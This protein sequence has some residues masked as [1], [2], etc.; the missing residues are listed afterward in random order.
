VHADFLPPLNPSVLTS[1][2]VPLEA[3]RARIA[4]AGEADADTAL[5]IV[6]SVRQVC[7]AVAPT[8]IE[9]DLRGVSFLGAAGVA[10]LIESQVFAVRS[11]CRVTIVHPQPFVS[12]ILS[13]CG[14]PASA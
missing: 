13:V 12:R 11:G 10:A 7:D 9:I 1:E 6:H 3:G 5:G 2:F 14:V 8:E 4:F